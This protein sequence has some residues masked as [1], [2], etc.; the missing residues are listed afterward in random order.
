M[1]LSKVL[2]YF[3]FSAPSAVRNLDA[4][5]TAPTEVTLTWKSPE[6]NNG[7]ILMYMIKFIGT[8]EVS[9]CEFSDLLEFIIIGQ[10]LNQIIRHFKKRR[11]LRKNRKKILLLEL[12]IKNQRNTNVILLSYTCTNQMLIILICNTGVSCVNSIYEITSC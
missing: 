11:K 3:L 2:I 1:N 7:E 10:H 5:E 8:K 6:E 4:K 9:L 12:E